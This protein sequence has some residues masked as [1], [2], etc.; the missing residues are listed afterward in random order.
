MKKDYTNKE[1]GKYVDEMSPNSNFVKNTIMAFI[2]GG[3]ICII[4]EGIGDYMR[5]RQVDEEVVKL[6]L[7]VIMI[8]IAAFL[9]GLGLYEKI[10]KFAGAGT[11]VPITGFANAVCSP[12]MEFKSEGIIMGIGTKMFAVAGPVIVFGSIS[13]IVVGFLYFL[14]G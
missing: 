8:A 1:Y 7:P 5:M 4:A 11:I 6:S 12:S 10:A 3:I 14:F 2:V 9:T 13:S